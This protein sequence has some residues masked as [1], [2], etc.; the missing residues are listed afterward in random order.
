MVRTTPARLTLA[1]VARKPAK[2]PPRPSQAV[3]R[4]SLAP[5]QFR[6]PNQVIVCVRRKTRREVLHALNLTGRGS[7][8]G[9]RRRN[10]WSSIGC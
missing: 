6:A 8:G 2:A 10:V 1:P 5:V 7:G 9:R 3:W 4:G